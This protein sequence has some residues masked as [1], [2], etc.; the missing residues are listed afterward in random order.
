M[1]NPY[2]QNVV[3]ELR[4]E[5]SAYGGMLHLYN[6]QQRALLHRD[7]ASVLKYSNEI[8]VLVPELVE[9]R[10]RRTEATMELAAELQQPPQST[11]RSLLAFIEPVVRPLLEA[12]IGEVNRLLFKLRRLHEHNHTMLSRLLE[13]HHEVMQELQPATLNRTYAANGRTRV[14]LG[15]LASLQTAV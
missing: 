4:E 3:H 8:E 9:H 1:K 10:R 2:W 6:E 15:S 12:L 7:A 14:A 11:L 13:A 5:L